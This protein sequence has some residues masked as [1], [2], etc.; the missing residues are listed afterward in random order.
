[1]TRS[2]TE[3]SVDTAT[4]VSATAVT[5]SITLALPAAIATLNTLLNLPPNASTRRAQLLAARPKLHRGAGIINEPGTLTWNELVTTDTD[6]AQR[7]Y[8]KVFGWGAATH[9]EG[10][11]ANLLRHLLA[12]LGAQPLVVPAKALTSGDLA[13]E[14]DF[15]RRL[16]ATLATESSRFR[17]RIA[18]VVTRPQSSEAEPD[19]GAG[20]LDGGALAGGDRGG[21]GGR[22]GR[23]GPGRPGSRYRRRCAHGARPTGFRPPRAKQGRDRQDQT[24]VGP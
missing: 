14:G 9:G 24:R 12:L 15:T 11:G 23:T 17:S 8:E 20:G 22:A 16:D 13:I 1:M 2:R 19:D 21:A 6:E 18:Q 7:F 3:T 4:S 5:T 10:V